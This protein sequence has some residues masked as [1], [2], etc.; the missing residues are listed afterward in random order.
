MAVEEM[1]DE[2]V[3]MIETV[4]DNTWV[5]WVGRLVPNFAH[6]LREEA[7]V[8]DHKEKERKKCEEVEVKERLVCKEAE[9]VVREEAER[10]A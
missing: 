3:R 1:V 2:A 6:R 10:V 9:R 7:D 5:T 8:R 4:V